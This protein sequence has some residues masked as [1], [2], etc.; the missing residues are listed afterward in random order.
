MFQR[1][2][3]FAEIWQAHTRVRPFLAPT[4]LRQALALSEQFDAEI[5]LKLENWQPTGS[6]KVR[7]AFNLLAQLTPA[8]SARGLVAA[9]AGNHGS[10]IGYAAQ[11]LRL[12]NAHIFVPTTT[13]RA[14]VAKMKR[15]GVNVREVGAKYDDAHHAA[16]EYQR[17]H[18]ATFAHAYDDARTVAGAGTTALEILEQLPTVEVVLIPVGGG[19]L[20]AGMALAFKQLAP[21]VRVIGIQPDASPALRDSLRDNICYKEYTAAPTLC[22]GLAGGIGEI[23][24]EIARQKLI[25]EVMVVSERATRQ[26][27]AAFARDEQLIIEG[28]GAV[29]LAT[30]FENPARFRRQRVALVLSGA[31]IDAARLRHVLEIE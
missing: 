6:F 1:P 19:G 21:R 22:D 7:G 12:P 5:F 14:K 10:A 8:E 11:R 16:D 23:V 17:A 2:P 25:D 27:I 18:N 4:P 28:S 9:S 20:S 29:G 3:T 13:P 31:N 30:L 26:A 15:Y 24:F